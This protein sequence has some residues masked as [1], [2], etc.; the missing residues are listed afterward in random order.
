MAAYSWVMSAR[1][2][3]SRTWA[4][5]SPY[6]RRTAVAKAWRNWFGLQY[7][8]CRS[9]STAASTRDRFAFSTARAM[10]WL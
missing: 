9:T 10:A 1:A 7:G 6:V 2:C 5:S 8:T 3:P 4:A